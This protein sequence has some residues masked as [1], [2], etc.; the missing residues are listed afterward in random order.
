MRS[1]FPLVVRDVLKPTRLDKKALVF[2]D[3][4]HGDGPTLDVVEKVGLHYLIG[5]NKLVETDKVL[6]NL[7]EVSWEDTG[8][9]PARKIEKSGICVCR[10]QCAGWEK[11]RTL[12]GRRWRFE[13]SFLYFYSGVLTDLEPGDVRHIM[14][15]GTS[16]TAALWHL[17]NRKMGME[18]YYKE[19]LEDL[20]LHHP[21]CQEW[22]RNA[23]F[24]AL[25]SLAHLLGRAVDLLGGRGKS[26]GE[27]KRKDGKKRQRP[28]PLRM[29]LWRLRRLLFTLPARVASHSRE[30]LVT[31][32]GVPPALQNLIRAYW[33]NILKC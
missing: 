18:D 3:S 31:F 33:A 5:A 1:L 14:N 8:A 30:T 23:G 16:Y 26:R 19:P 27:A 15:R 2:L 7:A 10:I 20:G 6:Q 22:V 12:V 4:L 9:D 21:P 11:A 28:T 29:R 13:G 17:Y 24:Y 32:L 25:A